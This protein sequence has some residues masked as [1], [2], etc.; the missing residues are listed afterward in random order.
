MAVPH[1]RPSAVPRVQR[2]L[3]SAA[4]QQR[5]ERRDERRR[6]HERAPVSAAAHGR[7][8][9]DAPRAATRPRG[10]VVEAHAPALELVHEPSTRSAREG[11]R[12]H[13]IA[14]RKELSAEVL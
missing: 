12:D 14:P 4:P 1:E 9:H 13:R 11:A 5:V 6:G 10:R 7:E 2:H 3:P 8:L